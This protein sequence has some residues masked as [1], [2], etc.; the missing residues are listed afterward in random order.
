[1]LQMMLHIIRLP[2]QHFHL[3]CKIA[4]LMLSN[5]LPCINIAAM[6]A[7]AWVIHLVRF[8]TAFA[9]EVTPHRF[10]PDKQA[11]MQDEVQTLFRSL[12]LVPSQ[13]Q[14]L[15]SQLESA[16]RVDGN[17]NLCGIDLACQVARAT[18]GSDSVATKPVNQ[19]EADGNWSVIPQYCELSDA[20]CSDE[21]LK[22]ARQRRHVSYVRN[23]LQRSPRRLRLS[24][25]SKQSFLSVA[26]ATLQIQ[27][28]P[29]STTLVSSSICRE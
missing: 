3:G 19:T 7:Y 14:D 21:G 6:L 16:Q 1:M 18:L 17:I 24:A 4:L 12:Q 15:I 11:T 25:T 8:S 23:R 27:A 10:D 26:A 5:M 29:V 22:H 20:N 9:T 28:G 13:H 2:Q